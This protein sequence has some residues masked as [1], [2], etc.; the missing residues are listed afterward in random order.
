M[1]KPFD[2]LLPC[3]R[4]ATIIGASDKPQSESCTPTAAIKEVNGREK[5]CDRGTK[6]SDVVPVHGTGGLYFFRYRANIYQ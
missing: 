1:W 2:L 5:R 4:P 3:I 6:R